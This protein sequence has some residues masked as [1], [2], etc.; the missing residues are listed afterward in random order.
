[1]KALGA[2][3]LVLGL[4][5]FLLWFMNWSMFNLIDERTKAIITITRV[6]G[7]LQFVALYG[8]ILMLALAA[9]V[10]PKKANGNTSNRY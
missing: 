8:A 4:I 3:G 1:M 10:G 5:S 7:F 2:T 6:A 9:I